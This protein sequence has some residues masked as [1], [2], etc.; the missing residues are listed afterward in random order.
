[1]YATTHRPRG[2]GFIMF[3]SEEAV[4]SVMQN[5]FHEL[6]NKS[7]EVKRDVPK[8]ATTN[9]GRNHTNSHNM[10][11]GEGRGSIIGRYSGGYP[12]YNPMYNLYTGYGPRLVVS[13]PYGAFGG[14]PMGGYGGVGFGAAPRSPWNGPRIVGLRRC[15]VPSVNAPFHPGYLNG[16][17]G[18][19]VGMT[20][21][22]YHGIMGPDTNGKWNQGSSGDM[23]LSAGTSPMRLD[24]G[25]SE[26]DSFGLMGS[27]EAAV[28][29]QNQR[30]P[31]WTIKTIPSWSLT[32][33]HVMY[34]E[35]HI[36]SSLVI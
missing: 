22:D 31:G 23:Q 7:V 33:L 24:N 11:N 29:K 36:R 34:C 17:V 5:N 9:S 15:L 30:A 10:R 26:D 20:T 25:I 12:T 28:G 2:F 21:A 14:F 16:G 4:E 18:G 35:Y 32:S 6:N 8:D 19:Y 27:Y 13:Y 1:M 3:D